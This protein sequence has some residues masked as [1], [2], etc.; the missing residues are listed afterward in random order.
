MLFV[1][2]T[3]HVEA[4]ATLVNSDQI[5]LVDQNGALS[6]SGTYIHQG[7]LVGTLE[8]LTNG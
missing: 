5:I 3:L 8:R 7:L 4:G 1:G 2:G 6:V